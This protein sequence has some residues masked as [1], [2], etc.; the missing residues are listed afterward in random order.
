M[1]WGS[2][3]KAFLVLSSVSRS[4]K[5]TMRYGKVPTDFSETAAAAGNPASTL[6]LWVSS[7]P[8]AAWSSPDP[9]DAQI[10]ATVVLK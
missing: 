8:S 2:R 5:T 9:I 7:S 3:R 4:R 1:P 6:E 10:P